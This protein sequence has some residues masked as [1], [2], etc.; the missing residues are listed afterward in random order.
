L[1][2]FQV[3]LFSLLYPRCISHPFHHLY[4]PETLLMPFLNFAMCFT[5]GP[6]TQHSSHHLSCPYPIYE[7]CT[8]KPIWGCSWMYC[9][10]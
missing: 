5:S 6:D 10:G 4:A 1:T 2:L 8:T 7:A 9:S 3:Y